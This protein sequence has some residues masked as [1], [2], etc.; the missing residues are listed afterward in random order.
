[1]MLAPVI[2]SCSLAISMSGSMSHSRN[3]TGAW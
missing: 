2:S 1:M 3:S